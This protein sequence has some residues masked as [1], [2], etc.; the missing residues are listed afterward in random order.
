MRRFGFLGLFILINY[1]KRSFCMV[2][3]FHH[4]GKRSSWLAFEMHLSTVTIL[5]QCALYQDVDRNRLLYLLI[6]SGIIPYLA[7]CINNL[8]TTFICGCQSWCSNL[9]QVGD[10]AV[11]DISA[12]T[13]DQDESNVQRIPSAESKGLAIFS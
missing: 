9:L 12:T 4:P 6:S 3:I 1:L 2:S 11:L 8:F 5:M 13:I 10:V 7:A